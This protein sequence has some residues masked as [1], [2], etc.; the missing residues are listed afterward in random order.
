MMSN[1]IV[2]EFLNKIAEIHLLRPPAASSPL[3]RSGVQQGSGVLPGV[4]LETYY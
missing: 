4:F 3:R 1:L 2:S